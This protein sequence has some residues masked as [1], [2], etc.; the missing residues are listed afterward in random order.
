MREQE[1]RKTHSA[2]VITSP[3]LCS[4]PQDGIC[5]NRQCIVCLVEAFVY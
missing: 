4:L 2:H 5:T 1:F 3:H